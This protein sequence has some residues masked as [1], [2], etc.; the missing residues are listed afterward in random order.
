MNPLIDYITRHTVR[1]ACTCG[2]CADAVANPGQHQ[3][4]GHTADLIFFKVSAKD[5]PD[6]EKLRELIKAQKGEFNDCNLFD[7]RDH[8]YIEIGG[9]IGDQGLALMLMGLGSVLGLWKLLTPR[10]V[11][12]AACTDE[13]AQSMAGAGYVT[14]Q[15]EK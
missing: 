4:A 9:W 10:T 5:N 15:V 13:L 11:L 14:I 7:G 1:G 12:G 2:R 6:T 3:P 8:S